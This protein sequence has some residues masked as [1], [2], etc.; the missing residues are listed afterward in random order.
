MLRTIA[1]IAAYSYTASAAARLGAIPMAAYSL[2]FN[3]GFATSQLCEVC[4]SPFLLSFT[5]V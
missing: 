2:T 4:P 3:L 5:A 1:K